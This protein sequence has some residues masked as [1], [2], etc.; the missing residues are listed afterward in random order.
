VFQPVPVLGKDLLEDAPSRRRCCRHQAASLRSGGLYVVA[1][2][3]HTLPTTST[4]SSACPTARSP[5]PLAL[6]PQ[7]CEGRRNMEIP[8]RSSDMVSASSSSAG[9]G[10]PAA[11]VPRTGSS[12]PRLRR[13]WCAAGYPWGWGSRR[14]STCVQTAWVERNPVRA[15]SSLSRGIASC[16]R[17]RA[18]SYTTVGGILYQSNVSEH[19]C[20]VKKN[21]LT[22]SWSCSEVA[23]NFF[24]S[25][26][27][28]QQ[29]CLG[30]T[31]P[32]D[33]SRGD[34]L[35]LRGSPSNQEMLMSVSED[36][37]S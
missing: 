26:L 20:T 22:L 9:D 36:C 14:C 29:A 17:K 30:E 24:R 21:L 28:F 27:Q 15:M 2:F 19:M 32:G 23:F 34:C 5:T 6:A 33:L 4:L 31:P 8:V 18:A 7:S 1:R 3:Y 37:F 10:K 25:S 11:T 35:E 12:A 16:S 13:S